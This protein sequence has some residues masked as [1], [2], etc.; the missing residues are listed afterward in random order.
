M[1][2]DRAWL[3]V[4]SKYE[5]WSANKVPVFRVGDTF[6][7]KRLHMT[8]SQTEPPL[9]ISESDLI[10]EMD[11]NGIGTDATIAQHIGTI[12]QREYATKDNQSR[13]V[14]TPLGLALIEAYNSMGYQLNKP[15]LR[16]SM[17]ADCQKIARGEL[18]KDV[19][20]RGCLEHMK[21]CFLTCTRE[22]TKL[23]ASVA[24]YFAAQGTGQLVVLRQGVSACGDCG[25]LMDLRA[26]EF[27]NDPPANANAGANNENH[28]A[29]NGGNNN[30]HVPQAQ[31]QHQH[32][33]GE[34]SRKRYLF[35]PTCTI[36]HAIP[37]GE[38]QAYN[39]TCPICQFQVIT[40]RNTENQKSHQVC[41]KCF[42]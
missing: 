29:H 12:Q 11:K 19:V 8:E 36:A 30:R 13:F 10:S 25:A 37:R 17:E 9:P 27:V 4:Y 21:L 41:P 7:P 34:E 31:L 23:D 3:E 35:C 6:V 42:K 1:V 20:V 18:V 33:G 5:K 24:K 40:I 39:H 28:G 32:Q 14:P 15:F 38:V 26:E 22:A 2:T 16:A